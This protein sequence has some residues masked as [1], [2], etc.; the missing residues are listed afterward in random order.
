MSAT[1]YDIA[2]KTGVSAITVSRAL[3]GDPRVKPE[4]AEKIRR[5]AEELAYIPNFSARVLQ[6]GR[7]R[8]LGLL[9][10]TLEHD[11]EQ[12]P[13]SELSRLSRL[14]HYSLFISLYHSRH[15][16]Y[17]QMLETLAMM[18][19]DGIFV[20]PPAL[21]TDSSMLRRLAARKMPLVFLDR[22]PG[23]ASTVTVVTDNAEGAR[24]LAAA[25]IAAGASGVINFYQADNSASRDRNAGLEPLLCREIPPTGKIMLIGD[26]QQLPG[27]MM[28]LRRRYPQLRFNAGTFDYWHCETTGFEEVFVMPQNFPAMA[29][30]AFRVMLDEI[31]DP[32]AVRPGR[33]VVP[34]MDVE[35]L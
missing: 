35:R 9:L 33:I 2:G 14:N 8:L 29:D 23:N 15:T 20:I 21:E 16:L 25:G 3:R 31:A 12:L 28:E 19:L 4:T 5:C 6:G 22:E 13:T 26:Y 32:D 11:I 1:I 27:E 30:V 17:E 24:R 18:R 10:P 7:T 34:A